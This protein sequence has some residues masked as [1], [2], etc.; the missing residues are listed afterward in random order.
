VFIFTRR[1]VRFGKTGRDKNG[2]LLNE[3]VLLPAPGEEADIAEKQGGLALTRE[4]VEIRRDGGAEMLL[5]GG[6]LTPGKARLLKG[7]FELIVGEDL[8]LE[9]RAF[10]SGSL[11]DTKGP[12]QLGVKGG[13]PY[14]CVR[15]ERVNCPHTYVFLV[16]SLRIG[17]E[18]NA[19]LRLELPGVAEGHAQLL[20]ND[21]KL[22][23]VATK[24]SAKVYVGDVELE[25]GAPTDLGSR[26]GI[27][28]V[29]TIG[30]ARLSVREAEDGD[31]TP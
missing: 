18:P 13:H 4:G 8:I 20:L 19:P 31:F 29:V 28:A 5:D 1:E 26:Q 24:E 23:V 16:R 17:S 21:G 30:N 15:L 27:D 22:Q 10:R 7:G 14:E 6:E 9:G 2:K 11:P 3:L 12:P 25:P